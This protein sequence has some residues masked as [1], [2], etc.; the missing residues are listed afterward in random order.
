MDKGDFKLSRDLIAQNQNKLF[1][2]CPLKV[3]RSRDKIVEPQILPKNEQTNF[4]ILNSDRKTNLLVSF[5]FMCLNYL[6][7]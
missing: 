4:S 2:L 6:L 1:L 7:L 3:S 5:L